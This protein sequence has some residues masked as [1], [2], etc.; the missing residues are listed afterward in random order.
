MRA[1]NPTLRLLLFVLIVV[2][3][4]PAAVAQS[5]DLN[6]NHR[7]HEKFPTRFKVKVRDLVVWLPPGYEKNISQRYPVLYMHDGDSVFTNWQLDETA[8]ALMSNHQLDP[9]II[10]FVPNGGTQEDRYDEYTPTRDSRAS[11]GGKADQYGRMLVEEIK[12]FIDSR[13]RTLPDPANTGLGGASLGGLVTLYLGLKYPETFGRLAVLSPSIWWDNGFILAEVKK[14]KHKP[15]LKIWL[16]V[17]TE[18]ET[19]RDRATRQLRD[20]LVKKGWVLNDDLNYYEAK[21]ARHEEIAFAGR[22]SLFLRFLFPK[23][24]D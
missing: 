12:P 11:R 2:G 3:C 24:R 17:G 9:L 22:A 5:R 19:G 18:E 16:D 10:V 7:L 20:E 13:Y 8:S 21:G 15:A 6:P 14:L 23:A 4:V 1:S